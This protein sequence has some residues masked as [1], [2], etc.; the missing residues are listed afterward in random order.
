MAVSATT[1]AAQI[2][3]LPIVLF[4]FHQF[5]VLFLVT[6]LL[7]VPLS[8]LILFIEIFM[9]ITGVLAPLAA[10]AGKLA[11]WL[12]WLMNGFIV[13]IEKLP[14][15]LWQNVKTDVFQTTILYVIILLLV[16]WV[17]AKNTK[18]LLYALSAILIF[19]IYSAYGIY[20]TKQQHKL[21]V[22]N[23][24]KST[25]ID[26]IQGSECK[27][28]MS[29]ADC[30]RCFFTKLLHATDTVI[31]SNNAQPVEYNCPE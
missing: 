20:Q 25:A 15:A 10:T 13:H 23:V 29:A 26:I 16:I 4:Y 5:P 22:Y 12:L 14:F 3:T 11:Y 8:T 18:A 9:I 2:F 30:T 24:P 27:A 21:V 19:T 1:I 7:V 28:L 31:V 6:N 17:F